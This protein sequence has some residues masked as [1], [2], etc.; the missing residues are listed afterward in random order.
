M[1]WLWP[2]VVSQFAYQSDTA[3]QKLAVAYQQYLSLPQP[4]RFKDRVAWLTRQLATMQTNTKD[5][6]AQQE[7]QQLAAL[8]SMKQE[9]LD[10]L[11]DNL[12]LV[13]ETEGY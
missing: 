13:R 1:N 9:Q 8:L 10:D 2:L 5:T 12:R 7:L 11:N 4:V 6:I 3:R